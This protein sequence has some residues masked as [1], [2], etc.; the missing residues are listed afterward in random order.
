MLTHGVFRQDSLPAGSRLNR[1]H[2]TLAGKKEI[3][4]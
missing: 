1:V 2:V 3:W 4:L